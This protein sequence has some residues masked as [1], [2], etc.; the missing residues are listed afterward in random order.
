LSL[1]VSSKGEER[2]R[3]SYNFLGRRKTEMLT[4][5]KGKSLEGID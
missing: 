5:D 2:T 3:A 4:G 1:P